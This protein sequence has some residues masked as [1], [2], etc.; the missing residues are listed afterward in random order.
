MKY[1]LLEL[2]KKYLYYISLTKSKGTLKNYSHHCRI[3]CNYFVINNLD[4]NLKSLYSFIEYQ[5]NKGNCNKTINHRILCLKCILKYNKIDNEILTFEKLKEVEK[6]FEFLDYNQ[7]ITLKEYLLKSNISR[8]NKLVVSLLLESG[9]RVNELLNIRYED[10][11][12]EKRSIL[13]RQTK[14]KIERFVFYNDLTEKFLDHKKE[15]LVFNYT[16]R[17]IQS[18]FERIKEKLKFNK[19]HA[20]MLRHTYATYLLYKGADL[21]FLKETLGH[22]RLNQTE[23]YLHYNFDNIHKKYNELFKI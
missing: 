22:S 2:K 12:Y 6:R 23:R 3:I 15:G 20:H 16:G 5:K 4:L 9:I 14:N 13:L 7:I 17:G 19:F 1:D 18:I 11:N 8:N 10:I 21:Y